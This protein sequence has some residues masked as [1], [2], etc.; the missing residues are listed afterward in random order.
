MG[1]ANLL[2]G[3]H[4]QLLFLASLLS[5]VEGKIEDDGV[6]WKNKHTP[7]EA[8]QL[9]LVCPVVLILLKETTD[10]PI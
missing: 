7:P 2:L 1:G 4:C 3:L 6:R 9:L 8:L 5:Q 10:D